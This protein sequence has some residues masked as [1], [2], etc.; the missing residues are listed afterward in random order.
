[1]RSEPPAPETSVEDRVLSYIETHDGEISLSKAASDLGLSLG[2]L[3]TAIARLRSVGI[4]GLQSEQ[5]SPPD[6]AQ[7][8]RQK[9]CVHCSRSIDVDARFC[10]NCGA[11]Q[12]QSSY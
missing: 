8:P 2:E 9:A 5:G 10:T 7:P 6:Q 3:Q 11:E 12:P 1:M 4:L